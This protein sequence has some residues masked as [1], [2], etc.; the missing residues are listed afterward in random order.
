MAEDAH[1]RTRRSLGGESGERVRRAR[2]AKPLHVILDEDLDDIAADAPSAFEGFG[3]PAAG[4]HVRAEFQSQLL[5]RFFSDF[6]FLISF[7]FSYTSWSLPV[8]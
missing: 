7:G 4:G 1:K 2:F 3:R 6:G 5:F 8:W